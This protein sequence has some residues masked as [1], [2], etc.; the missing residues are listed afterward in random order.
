MEKIKI[1]TDSTCDLPE[2]IISKFD[3]EVLPLMV[4]VKGKSYFDIVDINFKQLSKIMDEEN[5]F[6]TTSQ[7][8]PKRFNDCFAKYLKEGYKIICINMSS[9]MSGT[10]QSACIAKDMLE[11]EDVVVID[12]LNVTSGLGVLV[13]KACRL[14]EEGKSFEEIKNEII[15]T[16]PHVK[17]ALAF[18]RL[19]NLIKGGRLSKT[20]GTI[21][22][23]L[24]IKLIL[25][26]KDGEMAIK[27]KVRGNKKAARVVLDC[28]KDESMNKE[29]TT[30]LLNA[31]NDDILPILRQKLIEQEN[32][33][34]ECEVG[35][36][37][38]AHSGTKACGVFFI[39]KY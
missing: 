3:I 4:N 9:K 27:D 34:I 6:P 21:G 20:A 23:L 2:Y 24:G 25:E 19:D 36:V 28:I 1:V 30:L 12:S 38:G 35:C 11:S 22:N 37:V 8:T 17:S 18:E 13:L 14:R 5:I 33:F 10:Y 26:V 31:E 7:V 15:E 29:E 16:I 32:K 39:E